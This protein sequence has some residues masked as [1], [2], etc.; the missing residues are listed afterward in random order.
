MKSNEKFLYF[1]FSSVLIGICQPFGTKLYLDLPL[2]VGNFFKSSSENI[3][4]TRGPLGHLLLSPGDVFFVLE[5][6]E[7]IKSIL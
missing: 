7:R 6:I 1:A 3:E 4:R 2:H 5:N